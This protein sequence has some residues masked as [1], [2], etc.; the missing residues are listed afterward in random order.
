[1]QIETPKAQRV[2]DKETVLLHTVNAE[3]KSQLLQ[4][5][6]KTDAIVAKRNEARGIRPA[7]KAP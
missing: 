7:A 5:K 2:M 6:L 3:G 4:V 1:V